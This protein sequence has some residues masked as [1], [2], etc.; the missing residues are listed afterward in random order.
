[1]PGTLVALHGMYGTPE[2]LRMVPLLPRVCGSASPTAEMRA[3]QR[4]TPNRTFNGF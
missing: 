3:L 2:L 4:M 1:M